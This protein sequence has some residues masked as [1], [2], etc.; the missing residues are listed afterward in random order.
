M[1]FQPFFNNAKAKALLDWEAAVEE[2][3]ER[4]REERERSGK[5][6]GVSRPAASLLPCLLHE[7]KKGLA[8]FRRDETRP[9][10][11]DDTDDT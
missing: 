1:P 9:D 5:M 2:E 7:G 6:D 3:S 4:A 10:D 11:T 8:C